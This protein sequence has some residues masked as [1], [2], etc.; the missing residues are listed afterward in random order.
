MSDKATVET[1]FDDWLTRIQG[2]T[3]LN[4]DILYLDSYEDLLKARLRAAFM[5]GAASIA[6][7]DI[8]I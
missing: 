8:N 7:K 5:A 6:C 1:D 2:R 3:A 4:N